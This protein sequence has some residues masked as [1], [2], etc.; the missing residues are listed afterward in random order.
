MSKVFLD[1]NIWLRFFAQDNPQFESVQKLMLMMENGHYLPYTSAIVFLEISFVMKTAYKQPKNKI[2]SY[3]RSIFGIRNITIIDETD[4]KQALEISEKTGVKFSDCL[5]ASQIPK[6]MTLVTFDKEFSKIKG[7]TVKT[8]AE[9][10]RP[11]APA[12]SKM[13]S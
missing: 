3:L 5:I 10:F 6:D 4:T 11:L 8:P 1:S 13:L 7:L 9:V 12:T 2:N